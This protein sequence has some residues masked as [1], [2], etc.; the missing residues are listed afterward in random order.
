MYMCVFICGSGC[1]IWVCLFR[2]F[3]PSIMVQPGCYVHV[4]VCVCHG[5]GA[6]PEFQ[7]VG[8]EMKGC[9]R[10]KG[11]QGPAHTSPHIKLEDRR[12]QCFTSRLSFE[13]ACSA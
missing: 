8:G 13:T 2:V 7:F 5:A 12:T 6:V 9:R 3:F 10:G 11:Q 4:C 1:E